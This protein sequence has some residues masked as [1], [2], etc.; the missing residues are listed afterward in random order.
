MVDLIRLCIENGH[1]VYAFTPRGHVRVCE[2]N[3]HADLLQV[4]VFLW[5]MEVMLCVF[6]F[7]IDVGLVETT[8][9]RR[10]IDAEHCESNYDDL[11]IIHIV[12]CTSFVRFFDLNTL[13][14]TRNGGVVIS[15]DK[16][17]DVQEVCGEI[18][19]ILNITTRRNAT[20]TF[21][22]RQRRR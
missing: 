17:Q 6:Q 11:H 18:G 8:H 13:Q 20:R 2:A 12:S 10:P 14:A 1:V 22:N 9:T 4:S 5:A 3:K 15:D 19:G 7:L 16:F 21:M